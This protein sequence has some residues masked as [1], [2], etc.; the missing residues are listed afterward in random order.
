[1]GFATVATLHATKWQWL[2]VLVSV[3]LVQQVA[4]E[5]IPWNVTCP[6]LCACTIRTSDHLSDRKTRKT[7][8][9]SSHKLYNVPMS[10][11]T[12]TEILMLQRNGIVS[13]HGHLSSLPRLEEIDLSHNQISSLG[14]YP[15]FENFTS[16]RLLSL[17]NNELQSLL[18]ASFQGLPNLEQLRLDSNYINSIEDHSFDGLVSLK[19]LSL[20]DNQ[21][22]SLSKHWFDSVPRL[23]IL[24]LANNRLTSIDN[25]PFENLQ[26][27]NK[28][29]L[30][31]NQLLELD[32]TSFKGLDGLQLVNLNDNAFQ[33]VPSRAFTIFKRLRVLSLDGNPLEKITSRSFQEFSVSEISVN[34]MPDLVLV[35]AE[36]FFNLPQLTTVQLHDNPQLAYVDDNAFVQVDHLRALYVHNNQLVALPA[37]LPRELPRLQVV[38]LYGNP[39]KCD[40]NIYW[41]KQLLTKNTTYNHTVIH[42]PESN[43][44]ICHGPAELTNQLL[45][46]IALESIPKT[47]PPTVIP[48]FNDSYQRELGESITYECRAVG[49]TQPHIHWILSNGKAVNNTSN[50]SRVR[51]GAMG[52][53]KIHH[54]K[55]LDA[56]TYTCVATND[57]GYDTTS[58]VLRI[59]S[60]NIHILHKGVATNFITVTW[61]G[62]D[63]TVLT[64]NYLILYRRQGTDENYGR[65]K[66]RP[67]MRTYT[68]TNLRPQTLYEFCIAYEHMEELVKLN[69]IYIETKHNMFVMEGIKTLGNMAIVI[70]LTVTSSVIM[71]FCVGVVLVKRYRRRKAYKEPEGLNIAASTSATPSA[72]MGTMSH[73]PLDNLYHPPSTPICTSRTSLIANSNA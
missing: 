63:S 57:R 23:Q 5:L 40:C 28:L 50:F 19:M 41:I 16:L 44:L 67:Y 49:V 33:E 7:V 56:G 66:L 1:M 53:L 69:C 25:A 70:A 39:L 20:S 36:A 61:N 51:L 24:H 71:F 58:T 18:H 52:S 12:N 60:K 14:L 65:I 38:S 30:Q 26:G 62:T 54:L 4:S 13:V 11:P 22:V 31:G 72:K 29:Y 37:G 46:N 3:S 68:I 73:I 48:F 6:R 21:L 17:E 8:D 32:K 45:G 55:P 59:H 64:S 43:S 34:S 47:C 42:F 9:C 10:I 27:L 15:M 2:L 35:D